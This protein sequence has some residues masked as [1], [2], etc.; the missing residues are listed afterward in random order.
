M[1]STN[2]IKSGIALLVDKV[3]YSVVSYEHVKPGK[4]QAF[5][6]V[7]LKRL[8]TGQVV[9]KTFKSNEKLENA[10]LDN[11]KMQYLYKAGDEYVFMDNET[12]EQLEIDKD[13]LGDAINW[14]QENMDITVKMYKTKIVG[15]ELPTFVELKVI[16]TEP[17]IK[18]NTASG[19]SKTAKLETGAVVR[20][21]LFIE[22]GDVLKVDTR[23]GDYI[24]R[25]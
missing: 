8:D 11:K 17:G 6:R 24:T 9:E 14:M 19:G 10:F 20:V 18:G 21:P 13:V 15:I 3:L 25:A 12:F 1:I 16:E 4:G 7:R 23:T 2:E 5:V 22:T